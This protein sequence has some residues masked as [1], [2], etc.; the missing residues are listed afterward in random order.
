LTERQNATIV[1]PRGDTC[2]C[3]FSCSKPLKSL[4]SLD[5]LSR[6]ANLR[7]KTTDLFVV[8]SSSILLYFVC[9]A[10]IFR[11]CQQSSTRFV[12]RKAKNFEPAILINSQQ[13]RLTV[14][15]LFATVRIFWLSV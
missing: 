13:T 7:Y 4:E 8:T 6:N 14:Q 9:R 1:E 3:I 11:L 5:C 10:K 12:S 15:Y 2:N